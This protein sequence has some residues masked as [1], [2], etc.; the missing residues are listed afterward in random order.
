MSEEQIALAKRA[1]ACEGWRWMPGML[2]VGSLRNGG[3]PFRVYPMASNL[4]DDPGLLPDFTDTATLDCLLAIVQA[5]RGEPAYRPTCLDD[6]DEAWLINPPT[7]LWQTR[8]GSYAAV[9]VAALEA[10]P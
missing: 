6:H 9:L 3:W 4:R 8:H 2:V 1:V 10:A 5:A 7:P